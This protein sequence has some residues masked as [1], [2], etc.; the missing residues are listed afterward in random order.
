MAVTN[1]KE[2]LLLFA[3]DVFFVFLSLWLMLLVRFQ[4][5][6]S[7]TIFYNHLVPFSIIFVLWFIVFFISGLYEKHT[8][9]LKSR[10]PTLIFNAQL[11]NSGIAILFFYLV[12]FFGIAPKTNLFVYIVIS[13][14]LLLYWRIVG[15]RLVLKSRAREN[16]FLIGSGAEMLELR[17][18]VNQNPRY[19]LFFVSS[20]DLKDISGVDF[21][22]EIIRRIYSENIHIVAADFK[23]DKVEPILPSLYNL[24]FSR[25]RFINMYKI[26]EDTFD[27]I[28]LSLVKYNWFLEHISVST[29]KTYDSL[30]R[31][32]DIVVSVVA[33]IVSLIFYPFVYIA[34]K[35]ED[36][37]PIFITQ[38]RI[39]KNNRII[40]IAKF[41]SMT[42]NDQ[43]EYGQAVALNN[44]NTVVGLFLRKTRIDELPQLW[45]VLK[46]DLSLIG[47]RAE[48]PA[49][50]E[51]YE[52]EIPYYNV[53]HL[54]KPG[55]SGW[56]QLYQGVPPKG[57]ADFNKTK[58][59]L[60]Y[61]LYYLKNRSIMLDLKI[62]LK[63][64]KTLLSREGL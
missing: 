64:I 49:L 17:E 33:G 8:L 56:A 42:T 25:V 28:P 20:I 9:I 11:I 62:I 60:S 4:E 14:A 59:K 24:I 15:V 3:G 2:T 46:G 27:R 29:N 26:Y 21:Q 35:L 30:K 36:G 51:L 55:L 44:R 39:G 52:K 48:L 61:D 47:P 12:P 37:G 18:E 43:G 45:N 6:P 58:L 10:I 50:V 23:D 16:A 22:E 5:I 40:N 7:A 34:I 32:V 13:F 1:T 63:T 31:T 54:I 38:Q 53:R 57:A 41:R 19:G